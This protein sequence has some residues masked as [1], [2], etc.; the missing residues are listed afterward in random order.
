[1]TGMLLTNLPELW[2]TRGKIFFLVAETWGH[3]LLGVAST[4]PGEAL[5]KYM[6]NESSGDLTAPVSEAARGSDSGQSLGLQ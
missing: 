4:F 3:W 6:L 1:M 5:C 2:C